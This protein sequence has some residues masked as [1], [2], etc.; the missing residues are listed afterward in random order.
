VKLGFKVVCTTEERMSCEAVGRADAGVC[1]KSQ[2]RIGENIERIKG[3]KSFIELQ[4][5]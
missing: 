2:V 4:E 5:K 3:T 1:T